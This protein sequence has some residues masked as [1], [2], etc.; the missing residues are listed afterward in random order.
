M[1]IYIVLFEKLYTILTLLMMGL[2]GTKKAHLP[3]IGLTYPTM[4][5][6]GTVTPHPKNI[7]KIY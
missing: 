6:L 3:E 4:M 2:G 1:A 7:Q 5:T